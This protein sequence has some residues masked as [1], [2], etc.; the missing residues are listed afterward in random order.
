MTIAV[1][2]DGTIVHNRYPE[3]GA[4]KRFAIQTLKMLQ[5]E[6]HILILWT[7]R[8]GKHLDEAVEWCKERGLEFYA[9]NRNFEEERYDC[10]SPF[11]IKLRADLFIDDRNIGGMLEW[12]QIYR[13]I[14]ENKTIE[15]IIR[16]EL[17]PKKTKKHWWCKF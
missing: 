4:E 17:S 10:N 6:G 13:I 9:I 8:N 14:H 2:F 12:G 5:R 16:E 15:E 7:V 11:S 3:I 1:D